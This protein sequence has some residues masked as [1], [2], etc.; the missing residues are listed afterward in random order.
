MR[1]VKRTS[2]KSSR[3]AQDEAG[4]TLVEI[5]VALFVMVMLM[6][7]VL[8]VFIR[9]QSL[10]AKSERRMQLSATARAVTGILRRDLAGC[11]MYL[12]AA[13]AFDL[14]ITPAVLPETV[15]NH[16]LTL[17]TATANP[18]ETEVAEVRYEVKPYPYVEDSKLYRFVR[19]PGFDD[20]AYTDD[21][22]VLAHDVEWMLF[23]PDP[24]SGWPR[25]LFVSIRLKNDL[26]P[27]GA[28]TFTET[29]TLPVEE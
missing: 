29:V 16:V 8:Q 11:Y 6:G 1:L 9:A 3:T 27:T 2:T 7:I 28:V 22:F 19:A 18:G 15:D 10:K 21:D 5:M 12:S 24:S 25:K 14:V 23:S 26:V 20:S 13:N 4:F 17:W